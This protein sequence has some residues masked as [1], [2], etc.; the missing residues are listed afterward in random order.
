M[1][2]LDA[3]A[4]YPRGYIKFENSGRGKGAIFAAFIRNFKINEEFNTV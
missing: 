3:N 4:I 2:R 1:A